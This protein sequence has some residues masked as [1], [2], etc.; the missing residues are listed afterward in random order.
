MN[1]WDMLDHFSWER[2]AFIG[3]AYTF[4]A[5]AGIGFR[6]GMAF[7]YRNPM[8][9]STILRVHLRYLAALLL[10]VWATASLYPHLPAWMTDHW[11]L[12]HRSRDSDLDMLFF[13]AVLGML[14]AEHKRICVEA[15]SKGEEQ[16]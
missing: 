10:L 13:S 2:L 6:T 4:I 8:P 3:T 15:E 1:Q 7:T 9:R 16:Q 5:F 11:I 14:F 12:L